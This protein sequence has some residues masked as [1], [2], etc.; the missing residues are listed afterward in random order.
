MGLAIP[1]SSSIGEPVYDHL[2][3][4]LERERAEFLSSSQWNRMGNVYDQSTR[5]RLMR[6]QSLTEQIEKPAQSTEIEIRRDLLKGQ[7]MRAGVR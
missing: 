5:Q 2:C 3:Q 7:R 1:S 4:E 6:L